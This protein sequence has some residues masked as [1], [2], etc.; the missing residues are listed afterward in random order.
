MNSL[1]SILSRS[2]WLLL[3]RG[4]AA[5]V[6]GVL[7]WFQPAIS[8]AAL[9]LLFGAYCTVDG[10]FGVWTAISGRK[11]HEDWF[12]L[13]I[14]GLLGIGVGIL[15]LLVPGIT[16]LA[17]LFYI[18]IWAIATGVLEVVVAVRLRKDIKGEWALIL[19]GLASIV[20][21]FLMVARPAIGALA[22]LW[23]IGSYAVVSGALLLV[24][25]L[26]ARKFASTL[27]RS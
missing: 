11:V 13:L 1:G 26:K 16:A 9:V 20:F 25:A 23:L 19:A 6:F 7:I 22:V 27:A 12:M 5:I 8:L 10:V 3:L 17:L 4:L 24:V 14:K 18:A 21:G 15:T 2:W